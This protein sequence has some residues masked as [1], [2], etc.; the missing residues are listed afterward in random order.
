MN[1]SEKIIS[2]ARKGNF[3]ADLPDLLE[4]ATRKG[5]ARGPVWEAAA[6]AVQILFWTGEFA[7]AADLT[8]DLIE[9]DGPLGGEL[10][11][12]STPFRPALLAGQLYADE[13]AAPRLAA[14]AERIPDGRYMRR[15][16]EWLSQEL[17]R[18]GVEPL[19][20]CHSDWGG[21]VRPLD[22]VIGAGLV[23]RN[24]DELD[25]KQRRLV[26]EALSETNDFTRAHQLL[27]D[28]GEEP[29]QYSIC[30]WMAGWYA[31]RGEVEHGERMLLAAHSRW[32]PFAKWDAIP[33]AP[34]LQP[35]LRLVVTDKVRDHY[36]T[37]P[38]GP[39]AQA[40]E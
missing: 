5:G 37:R 10:C 26:W 27:T 14:C 4:I 21:A 6:A 33:D 1:K 40:A 16:F 29:E 18:Q 2:D 12:Q 28:T 36:L 19:L 3:L 34:V 11:D 32:W 38:I 7:Q 9:R 24:Y 39:E 25:R 30:L 22:G 31:T 23:D 15:D 13:A 20:P 17:P 35:T 8:Q